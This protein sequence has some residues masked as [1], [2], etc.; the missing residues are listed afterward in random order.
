MLNIQKSITLAL[1]IAAS[2]TA[3]AANSPYR[4]TCPAPSSLTI[5]LN[6]NYVQAP[7]TAN[8]PSNLGGWVTAPGTIYGTLPKKPKFTFT[9]IKIYNGRP[10]CSYSF[11][12]GNGYMFMGVKTNA[13][14]YSFSASTSHDINTKFTATIK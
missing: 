5:S 6:K 1:L 12:N 14:R 7:R 9:Q 11:K 10:F 2:G 13:D 4:F 3:L 8:M